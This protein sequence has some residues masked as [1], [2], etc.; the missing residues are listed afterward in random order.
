[1]DDQTCRRLLVAHD[2]EPVAEIPAFF[3][4][5]RRLIAVLGPVTGMQLSNGRGPVRS[6]AIETLESTL[7]LGE[8]YQRLR[9]GEVRLDS[10]DGKRAFGLALIKESFAL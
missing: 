6:G 1:M 7:S 8:F 10:P 4:H 2:G 9:A 5:T 3:A